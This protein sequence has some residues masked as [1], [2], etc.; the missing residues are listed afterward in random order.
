MWFITRY[1]SLFKKKKKNS[2]HLPEVVIVSC[3]ACI[4]QQIVGY[5]T[6]NQVILFASAYMY[7]NAIMAVAGECIQKLNASVVINIFYFTTN[8]NI[9]WHKLH[10]K[11][12][13][14]KLK[15]RKNSCSKVNLLPWQLDHYI[16][17]ILYS[18]T[19][20]HPREWS[21]GHF[22]F[23][24]FIVSKLMSTYNMIWRSTLLMLIRI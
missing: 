13:E 10:G 24:E 11:M 22:G 8:Q 6:V 15:C 12:E 1:F 2:F 3:L 18:W 20:L 14:Y 19:L 9:K 7:A 21:T 16:S 5:I 23:L 17:R 4:C